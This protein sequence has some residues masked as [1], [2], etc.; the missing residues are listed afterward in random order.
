MHLLKEKLYAPLIIMLLLFTYLL[1]FFNKISQCSLLF[2]FLALT[3]N[4]ISEVYG[5][6]KAMLGV[7]LAIV[8]SFGL[9]WNVNYYIY[10]KVINGLIAASLLS[11]LVSAYCGVHVLSK[12]KQSY[13]F[14]VRNLISL[15]TYSVVDGVVMAVFFLKYFPAHRVLNILFWEIAFKSLYSVVAFLFIL[16]GAHF[17]KKGAAHLQR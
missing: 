3:T 10:G 12:L 1:N 9:T 14:H 16:I 11:V 8:V 5:R 13:S 15:V 6:K 2:I 7:I 17:V 4:L